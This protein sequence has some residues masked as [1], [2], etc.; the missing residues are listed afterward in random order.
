MHAHQLFLCMCPSLHAAEEAALR[1][2]EQLKVT[3]A[4]A[5][6]SSGSVRVRTASW[7][8]KEE[9]VK[10]EESCVTWGQSLW[11]AVFL[12]KAQFNIDLP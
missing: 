7:N 4:D 12:R 6:P 5:A 2:A 9:G 11:F 3:A 1:L 10:T 8:S